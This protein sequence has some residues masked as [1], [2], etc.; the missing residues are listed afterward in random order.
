MSKSFLGTM[1]DFVEAIRALSVGKDYF[2][3]FGRLYRVV[4]IEYKEGQ[5]DAVF[6]I[7]YFEGPKSILR[8][9][10]FDQFTQHRPAQK[11][12]LEENIKKLRE[13]F[14]GTPQGEPL[15][16]ETLDLIRDYQGK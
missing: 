8:D 16:Q 14:K 9:I 4:E 2:D 7:R 10:T 5:Q 15:R 3:D 1:E 6:K 12:N 13:R 11:I